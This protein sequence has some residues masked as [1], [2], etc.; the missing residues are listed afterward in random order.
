L[1][2]RR[3]RPLAIVT[4][5]T[6]ERCS[7]TEEQSDSE[8]QYSRAHAALLKSLSTRARHFHLI[9]TAGNPREPE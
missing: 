3:A 7:S 1:A 5:P 8:L 4:T 9:E 6:P 2:A